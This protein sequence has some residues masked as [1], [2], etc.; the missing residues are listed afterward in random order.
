M[1]GKNDRLKNFSLAVI[2]EES[3]FIS[4][5]VIMLKYRKSIDGNKRKVHNQGQNIKNE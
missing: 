4:S 2:A 1:P 3:H 5:T